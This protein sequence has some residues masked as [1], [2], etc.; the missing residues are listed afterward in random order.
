MALTDT[1]LRTLKPGKGRSERLVADGNGLY[2][3]VRAARGTFTRTWQFRRKAKG[4][5]S[6][7]TLGTYP[8]LSIKEARLK[9][10][11]LAT[12]RSRAVPR[13]KKRPSSGWPRG[14]ITLTGRR[15]KSAAMSTAP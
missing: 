13:S 9:A 1:R 5:P 3:R 4:R 6:I 12:K 10:A 11:E 15:T 2:L 8:D 14:W 7:T